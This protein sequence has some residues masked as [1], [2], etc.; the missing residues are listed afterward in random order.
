[1]NERESTEA[2]TLVSAKQVA[3]KSAEAKQNTFPSKFVKTTGRLKHVAEKGW[4][5]FTKSF[6]EAFFDRVWPK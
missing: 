3:Q 5:I 6:W 1:M 2:P 4:Q